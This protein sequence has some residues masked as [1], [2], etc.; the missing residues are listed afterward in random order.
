MKISYFT[1]RAR[2]KPLSLTGSWCELNCKFCGSR[3]IVNMI[4]VTPSS[5]EETIREL[6]ASGVRGVLLSGGF[7]RDGTLP[8]EPYV[9]SLRSVKREY[10]LVVSAHLGLVTS[11]DKLRELRGLVDTV[12]YEFTLSPYIANYV[13]SYAF[14][15]EKYAEALAKIAESGLRVVPHIYAWHPGAEREVLK[16]EMRTVSDLGIN[17]VTLLVYID[18]HASYEPRRLAEK[19]LSSVEYARSVCHGELY[20]GCMRPGSIKPLVDPVLVEMGLVERV[21]NPYY[22]VLREH[23]GELYDACCSVKLDQEARELFLVSVSE[24][25]GAL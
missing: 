19:V 18:P 3:Y 8:I 9:N 16:R 5:F 10:R 11:R 17:A 21:A 6:Y 25:S 15:A 4:H 24:S 14:S 7:R 23:P 1:P 22:R 13:R 12:D 20:M 2:Y